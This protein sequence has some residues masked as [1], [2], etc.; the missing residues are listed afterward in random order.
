LFNYG[1]RFSA[2]LGKFFMPKKSTDRPSDK[3]PRARK[4]KTSGKEP[5][6]DSENKSATDNKK[7]EFPGY[8]HYSANEDIMNRADEERAPSNVENFLESGE[9]PDALEKNT[10]VTGENPALNVTELPELTDADV[11]PE[12][13]KMLGSENLHNDLGDDDQLRD[14]VW[15]VDMAG[16]DLDVPGAELDDAEE[17]IGEEDEENNDYSLDRQED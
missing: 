15:P 12:E 11:T 16:E 4:A 17:S 6:K 1:T 10:G 13:K 5:A 7:E 9:A 14:R 3:K 8:P 2:T